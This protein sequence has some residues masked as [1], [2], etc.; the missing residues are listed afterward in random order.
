MEPYDVTF[1]E[2]A[3]TALALLGH[4]QV[5]ARWDAPSVLPRMSVGMLACHLGRQLERTHEI[6]PI[7]GTGDPIGEPAEHYRRAAWVTATSLDDPSMDRSTDE[8]QAAAGLDAMIAR[9]DAAF[10]SLDALLSAGKA[11]AVVTVPWQGWSL[12]RA[13]FLLTRQ[14]EIVV[15]SDDLARSIDVATPEFAPEAIEPV[16]HLLV[17]LAAARHGQSAL[18]SAL[19]RRE[20]QPD[21]I[22]AF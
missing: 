14:L 6:L 17:D 15:H 5:R 8:Q 7:P 1:L 22:S 12:R 16:L 2:A 4:D 21:T 9:C 19:A 13:D 18:I 11:A 10:Q 20:R 3:R